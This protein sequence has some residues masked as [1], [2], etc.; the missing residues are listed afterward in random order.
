MKNID[1][2][3]ELAQ[4]YNLEFEDGEMTDEDIDF[5][6]NIPDEMISKNQIKLSEL[7]KYRNYE[8]SWKDAA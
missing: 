4:L 2:F 3:Y 7:T 1:L 5:F 8:E 6:C